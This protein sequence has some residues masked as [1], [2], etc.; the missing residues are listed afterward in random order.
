LGQTHYPNTLTDNSDK[1]GMALSWD[2]QPSAAYRLYAWMPDIAGSSVA[3]KQPDLYRITRFL[4]A[5]DLAG[6][7]SEN[8]TTNLLDVQ[9]VGFRDLVPDQSSAYTS[10]PTS[11]AGAIGLGTGSRFIMP[12]GSYDNAESVVWEFETDEI[13]NG[14]GLYVRKLPKTQAVS[15]YFNSGVTFILPLI[16]VAAFA[17]PYRTDIVQGRATYATTHKRGSIT[18][19][20]TVGKILGSTMGQHKAGVMDIGTGSPAAACSLGVLQLNLDWKASQPRSYVNHS[21]GIDLGGIPT[22]GNTARHSDG[23][24]GVVEEFTYREE[25]GRRMLSITSRDYTTDLYGVAN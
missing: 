7:V 18:A 25:A 6:T 19:P 17:E 1:T 10:E 22:R 4:I 12:P 13:I 15:S 21:T 23:F 20:N 14:V 24:E 11:A 3:D 5:F 8:N 16:E 2:A 9:L